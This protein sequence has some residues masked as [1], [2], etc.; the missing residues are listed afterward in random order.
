MYSIPPHQ[1]VAFFFDPAKTRRETFAE[2]GLVRTAIRSTYKHNARCAETSA[3]L[4]WS[5]GKLGT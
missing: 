1:A 2:L 5:S 3:E 4:G